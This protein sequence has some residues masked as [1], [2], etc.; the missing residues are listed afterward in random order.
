MR[1][2]TSLLL[3]VLIGLV[4]ALSCSKDQS[5]DCIKKAGKNVQKTVELNN[6]NILYIGDQTEVELIYNPGQKPFAEINYNE[7]LQSNYKFIEKDNILRIEDH[8]TCNFVRSF[9]YI[10][11]V[12]LYVNEL[13]W[14]IN[15]D[16][17]ST[18]FNK[19][20]LKMRD[21][22]IN[23]NS[24]GDVNLT[25][26]DVYGMECNG[27]NSGRFFIKGFAGYLASTIDDISTIDTRGLIL[28][29]LYLFYYSLLPSH[30]GA[31]DLLH[32]KLY[33]KGDVFVHETPSDTSRIRC[34]DIRLET[35]GK[36]KIV[37]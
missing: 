4:N 13:L 36:G 29:D 24:V 35:I 33:G 19:D 25:V 2:N 8:N 1:F 22:V 9:N 5:T 14:Q 26:W 16:G 28:H 23:N 11:K 18:V 17:A 12:K 30:V 6:F 20:S 31:Q 27:F 10:P 7:H 34:C 15:M 3:F 37:Q 32:I 21:L